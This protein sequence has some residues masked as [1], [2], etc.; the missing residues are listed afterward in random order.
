M[1]E[2]KIETTKNKKLILGVT[3]SVAAIKIPNLIEKLQQE[4]FEIRLVV[5]KNALNFISVDSLSIPVYTDDNEWSSWKE[6]GDSVLHIQLRN[7]A[8]VLL[9]A[10]LSANSLAKMS[11]GLADNLL[12]TI[13]RAWWW[14]PSPLP[15]STS[16]NDDN[17]SVST[18]HY[19][20]VYF[21][22]AMNT[23]MWHHPF[24]AEQIERLTEKLH[25][26]CIQPI[27]KKLFCGDI[28]IGA[29]AEVEE[30]VNCL[31]SVLEK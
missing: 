17:N 13:V 20:P 18:G 12:T 1:N 28:G 23:A 14:F 16:N 10:P 8:D 29:M 27:K 24:T 11:C 31:K 2:N 9:I 30:I 3:G 26:K 4:G 19:K 22:P 15:P 6:H 25:W 7:W 5:T 21:A